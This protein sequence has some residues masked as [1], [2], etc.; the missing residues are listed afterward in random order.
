[1]SEAVGGN[2]DEVLDNCRS[3]ARRV[4]CQDLSTH[5]RCHLSVCINTERETIIFYVLIVCTCTYM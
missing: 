2:L 4:T 3:A 5:P 1:M